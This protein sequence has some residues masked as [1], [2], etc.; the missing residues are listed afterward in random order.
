MS[1][2]RYLPGPPFLPQLYTSY[3]GGLSA[4]SHHLTPALVLPVTMTHNHLVK[5]GGVGWGGTTTMTLFQAKARFLAAGR[6][7]L[8]FEEP[9]AG[10]RQPAG[11]ALGRTKD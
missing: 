8:M 6:V 5:E 10:P 1:D 3:N 9:G 11:N 4:T 7:V 2:S